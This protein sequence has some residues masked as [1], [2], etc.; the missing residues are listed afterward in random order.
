MDKP[1]KNKSRHFQYQYPVFGRIKDPKTSD[2]WEKTVYF[3]WFEYL[4]RNTDYL[5]LL[6]SGSDDEICRDFGDPRNRSFKDWWT[7]NNRGACL[8]AEP[9]AVGVSKMNGGDIVSD[10]PAVLT[11]SFPLNL[12]KEFLKKRFDRYLDKHHSGKAGVRSSLFS[13]AKYQFKGQPNIESL[14]RDLMVY[15]RYILNPDEPLIESCKMF[16][17]VNYPEESLKKKV[18]T[19]DYSNLKASENYKLKRQLTRA[20]TAIKATSLGSFPKT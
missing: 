16:W 17:W 4:K 12:P 5:A 11:L 10:D 14:K 18:G 1:K 2:H 3:L 6:D 13:E 19:S 8:F 9:E 15:D 20:I 7:E